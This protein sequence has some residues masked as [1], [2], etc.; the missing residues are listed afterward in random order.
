VDWATAKPVL[1]TRRRQPLLEH[2]GDRAPAT[3]TSQAGVLIEKLGALPAAERRGALRSCLQEL[4]AEVLG[5]EAVSAIDP[6]LGFFEMG[7]DSLMALQFKN[8]V[9]ACAAASLPSTFSFDFPTIEAMADALPGY[10]PKLAEML[11]GAA[12]LD[13]RSEE[14][15]LRE[16]QAELESALSTTGGVWR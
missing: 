4:L 10:A 8:R 16:L 1:E 14:E 13:R 15:L 9:A 3:S 7:M 12:E 2:I 5:A 6:R 11:A